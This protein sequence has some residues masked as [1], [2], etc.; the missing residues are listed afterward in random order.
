[1]AE[2]PHTAD[3]SNDVPGQKSP[4]RLSFSN[5]MWG[6]TWDKVENWLKKDVE[7]KE[8]RAQETNAQ[9][10]D[11]EE[12]EAL[13]K[14]PSRKTL[15]GLP[16]PGTFQRQNSERRDRLTPHEPDPEERRALSVDRR[17]VAS[18]LRSLSP[19][20]PLQLS[21]SAPDVS[22]VEAS[23][24]QLSI[25]HE[26]AGDSQESH[27][28]EDYQ[29]EIPERA[30]SIS[31]N[32]LSEEHERLLI[33]AELE[34]KWILNL[35]MHFK[36]RSEREKFF[37]TYAEKSNRWR[38][39]TVSCDYRNVTEDSLEA[40]L[41]ALHYQRDKSA[42]IYESIRESLPDIQFYPTVTNLKLKT[43]DGRLHIHCSEDINEV[44][45]Y[46]HSSILDH[47]PFPR[48][49][50]SEVTF[51]THMSGYV[52]RVSV[53]GS[54]FVKKEIPGPDSVDEFIYE[55]NALASLRD[56]KN[57]IGFH[58]LV[59]DEDENVVKGLLINL[60]SRG[61]LIEIIYDSKFGH[62]IPWSR[63][64]NWARQIVNGLAEIHEAGFVQGDFTLTNIVV[65]EDERIS[66]I[67]INRRGCPVGWEP[68][69]LEP[70]I[71]SGQRI[72]MFIGVKTDLFQLGM[73]LWAIAM[74]IDEP[75]RDPRPLREINQ[76]EVPPYYHDI[77]NIC[78]ESDPRRRL[79][80]KELLTRF[81]PEGGSDTATETVGLA[82]GLSDPTL[83]PVIKLDDQDPS[84]VS[85]FSSVHTYAD[86]GTSSEYYFDSRDSGIVQD[87][88]RDSSPLM[89]FEDEEPGQTD[90][91]PFART[92][93]VENES[94]EQT[95]VDPRNDTKA[96]DA[97]S[98]SVT[99]DLEEGSLTPRP[100]SFHL[101][102]SSLAGISQQETLLNPEI[103]DVV[104]SAN[105]ES[106]S[107]ASGKETTAL[108]LSFEA[109][110]KPTET[111]AT[112]TI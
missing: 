40:D 63:R 26:H 7:G 22:D 80:A 109:P 20:I 28:P 4:R 92:D 21:V 89:K 82:T 85:E 94:L 10:C 23:P 13:K 91:R 70:M 19:G 3:S 86:A 50:E 90:F 61:S 11:Q 97:G 75:E 56:A 15:P 102:P 27:L 42:R 112:Q 87:E 53:N 51:Q 76:P 24:Q 65:H 73:V 47:I 5:K 107:I 52:Y 74:M 35:S 39:V 32:S 64:E 95:I 58:G 79:S 84:R 81:P 41:K 62:P 98:N 38:R 34:A 99:V 69:E 1:M 105:A 49:K 96:T 66:L 59:V 77:V 78:L 30:P 16:R 57:I 12:L 18:Y 17:A 88:A 100:A 93:H 46:P 2:A 6:R 33:Q 48:F 60:A 110:T 103:S 43:I 45:K 9:V 72:S 29:D 14:N 68:P 55:V 54:T 71:R 67:D 83:V 25:E 111:E 106:A 44:V 36:D 37:M 31:L 8:T 104:D 108:P 101:Q